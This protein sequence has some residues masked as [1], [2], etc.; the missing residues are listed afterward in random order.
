MNLIEQQSA[1]KDLPMQ[2][3]QQAVNGQNP[4][5][6]PWI[7]TAELQRR[8]TMNQHMAPQGP[9]GPQP[10]VKDQVEQKAGLMAT[11]QAQQ[12]QAAQAQQ[13]SA[14]PGPVPGGIPQPEP[15]P[16]QPVMAAGGG[17]MNAPVN[18]KFAHGGILGY[19][20]DEP[21]GSQVDDPYKEERASDNASIVAG[22]KSLGYAT[23]DILA[24][25]LRIGAEI[26]NS[27]VVRPARAVTNANIPYVPLLGGGDNTTVTPFTDRAYK[28][29]Q[30]DA[31]P[32]AARARADDRAPRPSLQ[33][34][35]IKAALPQPAPTQ[36]PPMGGP[37]R[38]P[39]PKVAPQQVVQ[40]APAMDPNQQIAAD[41]AKS[42]TPQA[43]METAIGNEQQLAKAYN[44]DQP[45]GV[46]E[47]DIIA[48]RNAAREVAR[49]REGGDAFS[50]YVSG[51][52]GVPGAAGEQYRRALRDQ[53]TTEREHLGA[54]LKD[55]RELNTAQRAAGEK[56]AGVAGAD[57]S[58]QQ[59]VTAAA[60]KDKATVAA[61][62]FNISAQAAS[63]AAQNMTSLE[64]ARINAAS[65]A[66]PGETER[67][68]A[69][70]IGLKATNPAKYAA[71]METL[72]TIRGAGKPDQGAAIADKA[73]DNVNNLMKGNIALQMKY[74][75]DPAAF[76]QAVEAETARLRGGAGGSAGTITPT[77]AAALAKYGAK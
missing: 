16:E 40:Q 20:G 27:A 59:E 72:S 36:R 43:S 8:T 32:A 5:L 12:A 1:A 62:M 74:S 65:A 71:F 24:M 69:T 2:Y 75:K 42:A 28:A 52:I 77:Q 33:G 9:Q 17:L 55:I 35:G 34:Q 4:N 31:A 39:A 18:F 58:K 15:Q 47:R 6:T 38:A 66:R 7:A 57:Y 23:Q 63:N 56:R 45:M 61:Q 73:F 54:N 14:P 46:E 48:Q 19:A 13:S 10:T 22:L 53:A 64:V 21:Q 67:I 37:Q 50:A 49:S 3:L 44:L 70:A 51:L 76:Q 30:A 26:L 11:Q 60:L 41:Y 25:P 68:M 29:Q